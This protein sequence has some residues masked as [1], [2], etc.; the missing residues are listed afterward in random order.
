MTG[1]AGSF[2]PD[3]EARPVMT[4]LFYLAWQLQADRRTMLDRGREANKFSLH[5]KPN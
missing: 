4:G 1:V 5:D 2:L 3:M